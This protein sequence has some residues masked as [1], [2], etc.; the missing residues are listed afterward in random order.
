ML[1]D[2]GEKEYHCLYDYYFGKQKFLEYHSI[3]EKTYFLGED[4]KIE[5]DVLIKIFAMLITADL[6]L[7]LEKVKR[8]L[9]ENIKLES[10]YT[11]FLGEIEEEDEENMEE[12]KERIDGIV[13]RILD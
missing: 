13:V 11:L 12:E 7:A 5:Y 2:R 9:T 6:N 3:N 10:W 8:N 1:I 4:L